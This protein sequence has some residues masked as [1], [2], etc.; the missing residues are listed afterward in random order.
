MEQ[1]SALY[2]K[3]LSSVGGARKP[4]GG[5]KRLGMYN[6]PINNKLGFYNYEPAKKYR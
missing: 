4:L 2:E 3:I 1:N 5:M 6:K